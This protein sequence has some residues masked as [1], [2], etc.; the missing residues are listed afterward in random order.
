MDINK[1]LEE[2]SEPYN[3]NIVFDLPTKAYDVSEVVDIVFVMD[4][5]AIINYSAIRSETNAFWIKSSCKIIYR[6]MWEW[7][8]FP[9]M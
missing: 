3:Y 1:T 2:L 6:L 8:N 5:T 4:T 7:L 9:W